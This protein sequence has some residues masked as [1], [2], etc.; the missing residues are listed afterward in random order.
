MVGILLSSSRIQSTAKRFDESI[1]L[2]G[3]GWIHVCMVPLENQNR[4]PSKYFL[5]NKKTR[6]IG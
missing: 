5:Y 3:G 1:K 6:T 4:R 2:E